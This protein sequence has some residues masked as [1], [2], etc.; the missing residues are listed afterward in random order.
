MTIISS[1]VPS[2]LQHI[3]IENVEPT[4][5]GGLYAAKGVVGQPLNLR[6]DIFRDGHDLIRA[7]VIWQ[8]P[9][10]P[11]KRLPLTLINNDLWTATILP[12][13]NARHRF[14]IEAWTDHFGSWLADFKKR[15][16]AN[17]NASSEVLEAAEMIE[18]AAANVTGTDSER[19]RRW[20]MELKDMKGD[21]RR[22]LALVTSTP[23][24]DAMNTHQPKADLVS[25][26][27]Y[28]VLID[29]P[30]AQFGNWYEMF[31]WSQGSDNKRAGTFRDA[32]KRLP[33]LKADGYHVVYLPPI[34]PI[35]RTARKGKNNSL[36]AKPGDPGSP[37]A[38]GN[39]HGGHMAIEPSL[40]T[41]DDFDHF[42]KEAAQH[43]LE[44]ALDFAIQVSPDHPWVKEHPEWFYH[45]PDGTIKYAENP[46]K[47]Y[48]DIYPVNFDTNN[49]DALWNAL[50]EVVLFW[51]R[52]GVRIFR[53]D[54]PHTK[55]FR[56]WE[57]L[58]R[59]V[60]DHHP[61]VIFLAEAFTR[62]KI[63]KS[64]AKAGFTQS[65]T[66]FTW[67]NNKHEMIEYMTE[68]TQSGM[69]KFFRP[70]FFAN[71]P[72]ILPP[73]LQQGGRAAFRMRLILAATLSPTYGIYSG[74]ELCENEAIPETEEYLNS[75]KYEYKPRDWNQPGNIRDLIKKI[76][77]ARR[78]NPALQSL[79]N[80]T[81]LTAN[82]DQVIAYVKATTDLSNV[83]ITVVN[84]NPFQPQ[85]CTISLPPALVGV[86]P[87][88]TIDVEDLI[89]GARFT[90][91]EH[92]Y[93]RLDPQVEPAHVLRVLKRT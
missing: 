78:D 64:L 81:F 53:V 23:L 51:I 84:M 39:E 44:V 19:L 14:K 93:V 6:A 34:H 3:F 50:L 82:N 68:L 73:V 55:P 36:T 71:T 60:Q 41:I 74:F 4:V 31:I 25:T 54:N 22:A 8:S 91:S 52:H 59:S 65:Y 90:W 66:Y 46:P 32:E 33:D 35:G 43:G 57:W 49:R 24:L 12:A 38:I 1:L 15:V 56:F 11:P 10:E 47:K 67:R 26:R 27:E 18:R 63:M 85:E 61:D 79:T 28:D 77:A 88:Q 89:T 5:D 7:D 40:G 76:N 75:E 13:K 20:S 80:I 45:R 29:R 83:I 17:Q 42:I 87:G 30:R 9:N 62:P 16:A 21:N 70:N 58:I 69:E 2:S 72:D 48:E 92:N 86:P 37:W